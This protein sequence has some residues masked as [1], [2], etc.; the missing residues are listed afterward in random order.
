MSELIRLNKYLA[1]SGVCSR[2][3]A[4]KFI[5]EGLIK[6]N[7]KVVTEMGIKVDPEKDKVEVDDEVEVVQEN[8]IYVAL[9]KPVG[10]VTSCKKTEVEKDIVL[11]LVKTEERL[12]P[13]GRLDKESQGLLI[14]TN[15]G[16]ITYELMHPSF[17]HEKEYYVEVAGN[18]TK[19][20]M[21]KL[22][23]GVK[24]N[25]EKTK[26][27]KVRKRAKNAFNIVLTEGKNRQIRRVCKKV[28]FPVTKLKR[29]R[30]GQLSLGDIKEGE[31]RYLSK[32]EVGLL[33]EVKGQS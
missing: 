21:E 4:D 33:L 24:L 29:I 30:I 28:G 22:E 12:Y 18:I 6:V 3:D 31:W 27:T 5:K 10:Y 32:E 2:R 7:G 8:K 20:S 25:G 1:H 9:N 17:D 14:L 26:I 13:V 16:L 15:D 19:G 11:D 23:L